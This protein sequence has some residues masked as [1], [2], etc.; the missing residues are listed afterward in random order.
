MIETKGLTFSY[1]NSAQI[2]SGVSF[3][4]E[5]GHFLALLGNNGAGKSTLLKCL[6]GILPVGAKTVYAD[7]HDLHE[8]KRRRLAQ[9]MAYVEQSNE[10]SRL[11]V[12]DVVLMGRKPYITVSPAPEDLAIV[13]QTLDRLELR[14]FAMRYVDELSGGELQKVVI[15]RA[16]AQ[17]PKI[18]LLDEPTSNLDLRNQ[19]EV[20][21]LAA[22]L[23]FEDQMLVVTVIH[24]LNL[25]LRYCDRFL[26]M[27]GGTVYR[28]GDESVLTP[29]SIEAVYGVQTLIAEIDGQKTVIVLGTPGGKDLKTNG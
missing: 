1:S 13:E 6:N 8:M 19:H 14:P 9:T 11:T 17:R 29:A 3:S 2:L 20:M 28:Y 25:A 4:A 10:A 26:L 15:A 16:V 12:Y 5:G 7:G 21:A 23:A 27:D 18:L 22:S 24:D